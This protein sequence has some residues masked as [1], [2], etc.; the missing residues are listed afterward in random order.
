MCAD[1]RVAAVGVPGLRPPRAKPKPSPP[2]CPMK[3]SSMDK[4]SG[5]ACN[6]THTVNIHARGCVSLGFVVVHGCACMR[7]HCFT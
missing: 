4:A 1:R 6:H 5:N 3:N 7:F 2:S